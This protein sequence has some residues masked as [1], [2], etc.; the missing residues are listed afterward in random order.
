MDFDSFSAGK[1]QTV[2]KWSIL[3]R[4]SPSGIIECPTGSK[5]FEVRLYVDADEL[6]D[7]LSGK[8]TSGGFLLLYGPG[9]V[10]PLRLGE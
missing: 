7:R 2:V 5:N 9:N 1:P 8:S 10:F 6:Q 4:F 3:F